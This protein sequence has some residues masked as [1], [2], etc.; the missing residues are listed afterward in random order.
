MA[1]KQTKAEDTATETKTRT[2]RT[3]KKVEA[4]PAEPTTEARGRKHVHPQGKTAT[5]A[6]YKALA[7]KA[8]GLERKSKAAITTLAIDEGYDDET[9]IKLVTEINGEAPTM[10]SITA[11]RRKHFRDMAKAA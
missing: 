5:A 1:R 6:Q 7:K 10:K 4:K 2:R 9:A 3:R 11:I 8:N